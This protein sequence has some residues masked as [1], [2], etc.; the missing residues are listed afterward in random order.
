MPFVES[1]VGGLPP[2][3]AAGCGIGDGE[4]AGEITRGLGGMGIGAEAVDGTIWGTLCDD[5]GESVIDPN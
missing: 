1:P 2:P 5:A 4:C 3:L